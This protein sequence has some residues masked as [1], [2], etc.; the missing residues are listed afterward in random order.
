MENPLPPADVTFRLKN[1]PR[2][3]AAAPVPAFE[4]LR[5]AYHHDVAH[6]P[7]LADWTLAAIA[8]RLR[9]VPGLSHPQQRVHA[10]RAR[11]LG[12]FLKLK[13]E[14]PTSNLQAAT[15][16]TYTQL[17]DAR[18]ALIGAGLLCL[19][20]NGPRENTTEL[21]PAGQAWLLELVEPGTVE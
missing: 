6:E 17:Y 1:D 14:W 3:Q 5:Q 13:A 7:R 8:E 16:L 2:L 21:T 10:N 18:H 19:R 15:G 20:R 9:A 4:R 12:V 11:L